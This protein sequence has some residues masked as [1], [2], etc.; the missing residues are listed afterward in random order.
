LFCTITNVIPPKW[1][2]EVEAFLTHLA[3][4]GRLRLQRKSGKGGSVVFVSASFKSR[5]TWLK[6][7]E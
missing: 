4:E 5:V 7:V 6:N 1:A 2:R 3:V